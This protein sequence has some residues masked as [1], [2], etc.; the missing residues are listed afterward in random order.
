MLNDEIHSLE[1]FL[2]P[3]LEQILDRTG[4]TST[5]ARR[6]ETAHVKSTQGGNATAS[7]APIKLREDLS[8]ERKGRARSDD[9]RP[10]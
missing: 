3:H 6:I 8:H 4:E 7:I 1:T 9:K 10:A 2:A 5:A